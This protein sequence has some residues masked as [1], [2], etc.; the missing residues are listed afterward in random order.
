MLCNSLQM[1][2][3]EG[4]GEEVDKYSNQESFAPALSGR[5]FL[6]VVQMTTWGPCCAPW[7]ACFPLAVLGGTPWTGLNLTSQ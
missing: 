6:R 4:E 2:L 5:P 1:E 7:P 3:F